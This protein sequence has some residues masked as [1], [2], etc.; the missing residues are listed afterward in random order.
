MNSAQRI[1]CAIDTRKSSE[2][3]LEQSFNSLHAQREAC[4]AYNVTILRVW[5]RENDICT[6]SGGHFFRGPLYEMLHN[7]LYDRGKPSGD[8]Q[9]YCSGPALVRATYHR[10]SW[11]YLTARRHA[12]PVTTLPSRADEAGSAESSVNRKSDERDRLAAVVTW[13]PA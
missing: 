2:E 1:R 4:E 10:R 5:L 8:S 13:R 7:P 11:K 3:G 9:S 6:K 12:W